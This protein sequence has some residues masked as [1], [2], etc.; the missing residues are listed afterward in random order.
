MWAP[1]LVYNIYQVPDHIGEDAPRLK[2]DFTV[3]L[4]RWQAGDAE[5]GEQV[6]R[7]TYRE[8]RRLAASYMRSE[9]PG[10]TLQPTA[11]VH[12]L[13]VKLLSSEPIAFKD[14]SHFMALCARQLRHILVDYARQRGSQRRGG[15][16]VFVSISNWDSAG[17]PR[18]DSLMDLDEMLSRLEKED[19]RTCQVVEMRFFGGLSEDEISAVLGISPATVKR[20][21]TFARAWLLARLSEK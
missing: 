11:L 15:D 6:L 19:P 17:N 8:M 14:R 12:E 4:R 13:Y 9:A 3:L 16:A 18:D 5:A 10:H 2:P 7:T 21:W 1:T 20:D